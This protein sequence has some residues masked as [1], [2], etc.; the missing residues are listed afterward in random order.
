MTFIVTPNIIRR[1]LEAGVTGAFTV[2]ENNPWY[3]INV[4]A[5]TAA[6]NTSA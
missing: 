4:G 5:P 1:H 3:T 6:I 2:S